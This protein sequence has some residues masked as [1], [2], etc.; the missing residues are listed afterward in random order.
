MAHA[1]ATDVH[2]P[3]IPRWLS[4]HDPLGE[5]RA[6]ATP[7]RDPEGVEA[8]ADEAAAQL[9]SL[10]EDEVAVGREGL[11]AVHQLSD[12]RA[13]EVGHPPRRELGEL[14]KV[15]EVGVEELE[16][17]ALGNAVDGPGQRVGLV[18]AH[19]EAAGLLLVVGEAVGVAQGGEVARD[20]LHGLGDEVLVLERDEGDVHTAESS[21]LGRPLTRAVHESLARHTALG[22]LDAHHAAV[23]QRHGGDGAAGH[24]AHAERSGPAGERLR[25]VGGARGAV[26]R[27]E[28][29]T[30]E[31]RSLHWRPERSGLGGVEEVHL[32]PEALCGRR[33]A[34]QLLHALGSAGEAEPAALLPA[35]RLARFGLERLVEGHRAA[36]QAGD[37]R[38]APELT[39]E[40]GGVEGAAARE[41]LALQH[42]NVAPTQLGEVVGGGAAHDSAPGDDH[43]GVRGELTH[44]PLQADQACSKRARLLLV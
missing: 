3:E 26:G 22:R 33:L 12:P 43:A 2:G 13:R 23:L 17:E 18:A 32:Q 36:E 27:Q 28:G 29:R 39:D 41:L 40:P 6:R 11:G 34:S 24:D 4:S 19:D 14:S 5:R 44:A 30:H 42:Q 10:P 37:A 1:E 38:R 35:G 7:R 20:A 8:G 9:R 15:L 25:D 21:E 31:V 16:V